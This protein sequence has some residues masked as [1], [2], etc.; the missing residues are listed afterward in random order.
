MQANNYTQ[1]CTL[2]HTQQIDLKVY[3]FMHTHIQGMKSCICLHMY[4][5]TRIQRDTCTLKHM[6]S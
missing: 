3:V 6:Q 2:A 5:H 4:K 1:E